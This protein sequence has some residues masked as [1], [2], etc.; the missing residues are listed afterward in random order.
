MK[1]PNWE[2]V[3]KD[4]T[5]WD[6]FADVFCNKAGYWCKSGRG[7]QLYLKQVGWGTYRCLARPIEM[8]SESLIRTTATAYSITHSTTG[9]H[10]KYDI[11]VDEE[12]VLLITSGGGDHL[13]IESQEVLDCISS[14]SSKLFDEYDK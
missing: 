9:G 4:A 12:G 1:K 14:L 5:Q 13:L 3:P 10:T 8:G 11:N 2:I 6:D 7:Y